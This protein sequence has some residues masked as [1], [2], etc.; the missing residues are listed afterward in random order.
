MMSTNSTISKKVPAYFSGKGKKILILKVRQYCDICTEQFD[1]KKHK[2]VRC[3]YCPMKACRSCCERYILDTNVSKCMSISCNREWSPKFIMT[4][5]SLHFINNDLKNHTKNV[6]FE[7]EKAKFS[8]TLEIM[9]ELDTIKEKTS[10][11]YNELNMLNNILNDIKELKI[12]LI[13]Y[14]KTSNELDTS[15]RAYERILYDNIEKMSDDPMDENIDSNKLLE[16][17][18]NFINN[19]NVFVIKKR[20]MFL[21]QSYK[22]LLS[23]YALTYRQVFIANNQLKFHMDKNN[24][25]MDN[26]SIGQYNINNKNVNVFRCP[27]DNCKGMFNNDDLKCL[28]CN[29][30]MCSSCHE[31]LSEEEDHKCNVDTVETIKV[32]KT[33]SKSCPKC[34]TTIY[35]IDGCDQI[36]CTQCHTAFSWKSGN[37]ETKIHNPHYYE[38]LRLKSPNGI[39]PRE[40]GDGVVC[41]EIL[42]NEHTI[43]QLYDNID[44]KYIGIFSSM[45]EQTSIMEMSDELIDK[46]TDCVDSVIILRENALLQ[47]NIDEDYMYDFINR[48]NYLKN[49]ISEKQYKKNLAKEYKKKHRNAE[50]YPLIQMWINA[51]SDIINRAMN[52]F[53]NPVSDHDSIWSNISIQMEILN[54][55]T[56]LDKYVKEISMEIE[57]T[58]NNKLKFF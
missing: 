29:T 8:E 7:K 53:N 31:N 55:N 24:E 19:I 43:D 47:Y 9:K 49:K 56:E 16:Y 42:V 12:R 6:L 46:I 27:V 14:D 15:V 18:E 2:S 30:M 25:L 35:K 20:S 38:W 48:S 50:V 41:E 45:E 51:K 22:N 26:I 4:N 17:C 44:N 57:N 13:P 10:K 36:W 40:Q 5:F 33:D 11:L 52:V 3:E 21:N 58:Y 34:K 23:Y 39:I 54:E 28:L 32:L 1:T 37:V